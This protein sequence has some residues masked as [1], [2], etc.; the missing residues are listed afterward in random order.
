VDVKFFQTADGGEVICAN[1]VFELG[2]DVPTAVYL[3][4]FGGN[5]D[6]SGDDSDKANQWWANAI[7]TVE[8]QKLR[9]RLQNLLRSI[10]LTSGNL[11][12]IE[13][14]AKLDL[15]WMLDTKLADSVEVTASIPKLNWVMIETKIEIQDQTYTPAFAAQSG[16]S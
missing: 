8:S 13:D 10:P 2:E 4:L 9:S 6:D 15:Q 16:I 1:G 5:E 11:V 12:R 14:A 7:E 3:S